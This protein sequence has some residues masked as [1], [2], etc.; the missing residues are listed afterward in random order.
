MKWLHA[1]WMRLCNLFHKQQL[2]RELSDELASHLEMHIEDNL[3]TGMTPEAARRDALLKLGGLEQT[4][5]IY[6]GQRG[7]PAIET[8]VQDLRFGLR[9]LRRSPG[10]SILAILCLTLGIGANAAVFSWVEGILFRPYPAVT[11]QERLVA[12]SGTVGEERDETSWPDL[13]D[14]QRSCTL[15]ETLFV[16]SI[17]GATLTIG[18]RA[19]VM[20]GSIVSANYFDAI[21]VHPILGRGFEP[22]ED[23]GRNAHPV[24][25][26]SY[27]LWQTRFK[28]DPEIIGKT[29]R[30]NNVVHT[31]IG[32]APDRFYGT[33][34]GRGI[35]FWVPASMVEVYYAGSY[36]LEDR[37]ARWAE[38]YV[39]LKPGATR[40]QAQQ[41][42]SAIA[43]RLEAEYPATNRGRGI[44]VW[45]L[46]QTPF[47]HAGE[48]LPIFEI[49]V[50]VAMF[51]LLI[52]CANV[53][54]LLLVRSFAR[55]HEMTVRLALGAGRGR[56]L[57]QLV[58]EG[59]LLTACGAAGGMLVAYWCRH[60]LVVLFPVRGGNVMYL[61]GQIDGRVLGLS[62]AICLVVTL[63]VG[64]VP[65]FQ[66]RQ[67]ALADTLKTGAS[68]VLGARAPAWFRSSLVVLQVT[69]GFV[70]LVGGALLV[71][72]L[73]KIR[74]TSPGF[75]T[76]RVFDTW[77]PLA[78]AGYDAPRAKTFQD[79][80]IQRVRA[81]PGV[82]A[83]AYARVVPLGYDSYSSTP[84][85]VDGYEPQPNEQP[86]VEYNEVS[87]DYFA[88]MGIPLLSGRE[89]TRAD[90]ENAPRVAIVN[91]TVVARYW[92]GQNPIGQRLQVKGN[93]VQ[94][95][96]VV[97]VSKYYSMDET[98]RPFFYVPLRQ[99][100]AIQP[101]IHIRTTQPLETVQT[102]LIREVR[103][104]DPNLALYE[105]ITLQ[106]QVN[107]STSQQLVAVALVVLFG[108]LALLL[109]SIGL[110]G[111]MSCTVSQS[112]R[113]L[114]LRMALGAGVSN[115][116]R[117][118][119]SRGL[120]LT[121]GGVLLGAAAAL[122]LTRLLGNLL[123][124][125]SP[126]DPLAFGAALVVMMVT[127]ATS[128]FLPAWRATRTDPARALR[129]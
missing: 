80:L 27:H 32:V 87:A 7:L 47:N 79:E 1:S 127:A 16:S 50:V 6:R 66:T 11:H 114:G 72:S 14:L 8:A 78:A 36:K 85:A 4:K 38:A 29:E 42:I 121:A 13:L 18:E 99:Y 12:L 76:T 37:G 9:M 52:V 81:L 67:L 71:Q 48:L 3:R 119:M 63:A 41:E 46:W 95:V 57:R 59:L 125:V 2:D 104:L 15:C 86:T 103:A 64:L 49:M 23:T 69:L 129:D 10:F 44:K 124:Q 30:F 120:A 43:A 82:E 123:Y 113:E 84:I 101:D 17:T 31:I 88:T 73:R 126:L 89:F 83:A 111:V 51:V 65:A 33:F 19:Q 56:L 109:A 116:L 61:P 90:D 60:A 97:K 75:S 22:G 70:L 93:W 53:S 54:N 98:P 34:V 24:V 112:T 102:A 21:G 68:A 45:P 39:R 108:G 40:N 55:R 115:L 28:G 25:V 58:T 106:E 77:I 122:A 92:R 91:Q 117:L 94:V 5:E 20:T 26:I 110:Y 128:C 118:V 35:E 105:M 100:F 107:R 74:T 62:A 96:G